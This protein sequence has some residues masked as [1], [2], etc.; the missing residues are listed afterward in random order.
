M[1]MHNS[2]QMIGSSVAIQAQLDD[3]KAYRNKIRYDN[4]RIT[5][6]KVKT[7]VRFGGTLRKDAPE[8]NGLQNGTDKSK[9]GVSTLEKIRDVSF[10]LRTNA[11]EVAIEAKET[12]RTNGSRYLK[13]LQGGSAGIPPSFTNSQGELLEYSLA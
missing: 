3:I 6:I 8:V 9:G 7:I 11:K 10:R 12:A 2:A 4:W 1:F 13:K 5:K